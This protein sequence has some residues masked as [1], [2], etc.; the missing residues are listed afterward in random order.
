[1]GSRDKK[2]RI[3][4]LLTGCLLLMGP[5]GAKNVSVILFGLSHVGI[6]H[7]PYYESPAAYSLVHPVLGSWPY[8]P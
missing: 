5:E 7:N 6:Q 4:Q 2:P 3:K 1:M 8:N